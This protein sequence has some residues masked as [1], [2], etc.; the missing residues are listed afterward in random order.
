MMEKFLS[1]YMMAAPAI[2]SAQMSKQ[3]GPQTQPDASGHV[4]PNSTNS[5][6]GHI[7]NF[8]PW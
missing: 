2:A 8:L 5:G 7:S 1:P 4:A 3:P 6:L